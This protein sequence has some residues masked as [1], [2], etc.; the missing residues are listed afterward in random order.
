MPLRLT[1]PCT[2]QT[3]VFEFPVIVQADEKGNIIGTG[4]PYDKDAHEHS[5]YEQAW[6]FWKKLSES[7]DC[8]G[9]CLISMSGVFEDLPL[10]ADVIRVRVPGPPP[11][12]HTSIQYTAT[13]RLTV[14]ASC[15][16]E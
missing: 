5:A 7:L 12:V 4:T 13:H 6:A 2:E 3:E 11:V 9:E 8:P 10:K 16:L 14:G 15:R 1:C